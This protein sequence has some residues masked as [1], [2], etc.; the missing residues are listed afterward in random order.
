MGFENRSR[1]SAA[2]ITEVS[3]QEHGDTSRRPSVEGKDDNRG[4]RRSQQSGAPS[5]EETTA[6]AAA[7]GAGAGAGA[8]PD[9]EKGDFARKVLLDARSGVEVVAFVELR[10]HGEV[11][12]VKEQLFCWRLV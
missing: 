8:A 4:L 2:L 10:L 12:L 11:D 7:A 3:G 6:A 1:R 5:T 9:N